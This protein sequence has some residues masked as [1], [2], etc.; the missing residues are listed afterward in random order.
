MNESLPAIMPFRETK[1]YRRF[2]EFC[3][4]C[5]RYRYIGL[6]HG[7]PGVGKTLSARHYARWDAVEP[8]VRDAWDRAPTPA[9]PGFAACRALF[10]T[11]SMT[12]TPKR[13]ETD[14]NRLL[15]GLNLALARALHPGLET[16]D[17]L[18]TH[19][20]QPQLAELLIVDE[21]DRLKFAVLEQ[22][23][24]VYDQRGVGLVLIGMP[25]LEKRLARYAQ[26]YSRV[27]FVHQFRPLSADELRFLLEQK[28]GELGLPL[29]LTEFDDVEAMHAIIRITAGNFRLVQRLFAQ[30]ARIMAIN[31]LRTLTND[32][33]EAARESLVIGV[34]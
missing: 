10:Y 8:V 30:I 14:L 18:L 4:A 20:A 27:G 33:V 23:R 28:W 25:G 24:H 29:D 9:F 26:L 12:T 11:V 34:T 13:L 21:A 6:C 17:V 19:G 31:H 15:S 2:A 7:P 32:V 1:E 3:D 5:R 22:L 16:V